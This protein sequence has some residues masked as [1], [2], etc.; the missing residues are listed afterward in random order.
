M[1]TLLVMEI[2]SPDQAAPSQGGENPPDQA[3]TSSVGESPRNPAV[4][5]LSSGDFERIRRQLDQMSA[6]QDAGAE[7]PEWIRSLHDYIRLHLD[8]DLSLNDLAERCHFHPVYLSSA[9]RK[10][11][12]V[13]LSDYINAVRLEKAREF[14]LHTR[15]SVAEISRATGFSTSNYFCRW[16]RK[17]TGLSPQAWRKA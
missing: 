16:F 12:G 8:Q 3:A 13:S 6:D 1:N 15:M 9:Y 11:T 2:P 5:R 7:A 10:A 14:L 17:Q 4:Y